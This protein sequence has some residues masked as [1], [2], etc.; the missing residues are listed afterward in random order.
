MDLFSR[1]TSL[2]TRTWST[3]TFVRVWNHLATG[4][5]LDSLKL[6]TNGSFV[7]DEGLFD[8]DLPQLT[9]LHLTNLQPVVAGTFP[10]DLLQSSKFYDYLHL[11]KFL[12]KAK[13]PALRTLK[14]RG[15][16]DASGAATLASMTMGDLAG[17][18]PLVHSLLG[19]LKGIGANELRLANSSGHADANAHGVFSCVDGEWVSRVARFW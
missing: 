2:A 5:Q 6:E 9:K 14:L 12:R 19:V 11:A 17:E 4:T 7:V 8:L 3:A 10:T 18:H 13:L 1:E 15:W 16:V